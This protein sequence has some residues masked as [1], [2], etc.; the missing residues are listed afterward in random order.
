MCR[1][2][3]I[4]SVGFLQL[5]ERTFEVLATALELLPHRVRRE[6]EKVRDF[7]VWQSPR[8]ELHDL[9]LLDPLDHEPRPFPMLHL[10]FRAR[11][12]RREPVPRGLLRVVLRAPERGAPAELP[13]PVGCQV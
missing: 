8:L 11:D 3:K 2:R 4:S 12:D 7:L 1:R 9:E 10:L 13:L 6:P 5:A